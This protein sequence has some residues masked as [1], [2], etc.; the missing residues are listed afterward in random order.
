M[1]EMKNAYILTQKSQTRWK[2]VIILSL[3]VQD[4]RLWTGSKW[5]SS[6]LFKHFCEGG[7][8]L[9]GRMTESDL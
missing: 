4:V 8:G 9:V 2:G 7:N 3:E 5:F 6:Y 1:G